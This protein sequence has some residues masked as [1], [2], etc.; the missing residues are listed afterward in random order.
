MRPQRIATSLLLTAFFATSAQAAKFQ[1]DPA[2]TSI[3]F[4]VPHMVISKVKGRFEKFEGSFDFD[5]KSQK[6][7][8]VVVKIQADSINTNQADRD[9]HLKSPDFLDVAKFPTID[10]KGTKVIYDTAKPKEVQG[11]LTIHGI[12]KDA[13]LEVE[14]KGAVTDPMGV[15]RIGFEIETKLNRKD[16]GLIWNKALETGGVVVGD[17]IEV[18][19]EGEAILPGKAK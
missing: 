18:E 11:K 14:Y 1:I 12:T 19:I 6:L 16:F 4:K 5:E 2:H 17:N 9:K 13:T 7:D 15:R 8:N 3:T 10:F